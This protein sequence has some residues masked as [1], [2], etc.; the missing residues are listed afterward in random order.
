MLRNCD[1][2]LSAR[3]DAK[4]FRRNRLSAGCGL[5]LNRI[6]IRKSSGQKCEK[7]RDFSRADERDHGVTLNGIDAKEPIFRAIAIRP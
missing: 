6:R 3:I 1:F 5:K 2:P 7:Q 4:F